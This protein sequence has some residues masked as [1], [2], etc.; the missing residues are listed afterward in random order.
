MEKNRFF[1]SEIKPKD[2]LTAFLGTFIFFSVLFVLFLIFGFRGTSIY[3]EPEGAYVILGDADYGSPGQEAQDNEIVNTEPQI[4]VHSSEPVVNEEVV[5]QDIEETSIN[6]TNDKEEKKTD[7]NQP[8]RKSDPRFE[9]NAAKGGTGVKGNT[10]QKGNQ[11]STNGD[12][13]ATK[14]GPGGGSGNF[15]FNLSG[16]GL[17]QGP[18]KIEDNSQRVEK[19]VIEIVVNRNGY[20][21]RAEAKAKGGATTTTGPI[22]DKAIA[23]AKKVKFTPNPNASEEQYGT[24]TFNFTLK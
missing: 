16:R 8:E 4:P 9:F 21:I 7:E 17:V 20:V 5:T 1:K 12:P 19:V 3:N 6:M 23:A 14:Y 13:N 24:I 15:S 18:P 10:D 2:K 22:V 11:G